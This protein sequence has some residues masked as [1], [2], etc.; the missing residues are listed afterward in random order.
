MGL[1]RRS[2]KSEA[3]VQAGAADKVHPLPARKIFCHV[4][5]GERS[6]SR[7]W[8]RPA[9]V[10]TCPCCKTE[11]SDPAALYRRFQP[12]CPRCGEFLEQPNFEYG[13]C[14]GCGSK[15]EIMPG[16]KPGLIPNL[17]QRQEMDKHGKARSPL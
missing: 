3:A 16:T 2:E 9:V 14:D 17:K 7:C 8:T 12:S 10:R 13:L 11:F 1:F 15:F 4:C 5:A 6:F